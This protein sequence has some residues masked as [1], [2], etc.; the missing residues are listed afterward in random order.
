MKTINI[1]DNL[2]KRLHIKAI[3]EEC[4]LRELITKALEDY[5]NKENNEE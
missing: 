4:K 5:L 2:H 3:N 1:D